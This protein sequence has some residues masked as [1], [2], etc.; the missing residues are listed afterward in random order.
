MMLPFC[1]CICVGSII[2]IARWFVKLGRGVVSDMLLL[3]DPLLS[4]E[5]RSEYSS[6]AA[7]SCLASSFK[8][9]VHDFD[10]CFRFNGSPESA[11]IVLLCCNIC[12]LPFFGDRGEPYWPLGRTFGAEGLLAC[13]GTF[14][15]CRFVY[16]GL[17]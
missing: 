8:S 2:V 9:S 16:D 17:R 4:I 6:S 10:R 14:A 7:D 15:E 13:L 1:A 3:A 12:G 5:S 11:G